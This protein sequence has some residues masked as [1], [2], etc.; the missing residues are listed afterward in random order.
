MGIKYEAQVPIGHYVVDFLVRERCLVVQVDGD[1]W[2][3][4]PQIY[5]DLSALQRKVRQ[6]DRACNTYLIRKGYR[7][8]RLW[9]R[10][11]KENPAELAAHIQSLMT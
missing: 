7:V 4:N 3:A 8:C 6:R 9:E 5:S 11:I 10:D 2:Y 1:Y